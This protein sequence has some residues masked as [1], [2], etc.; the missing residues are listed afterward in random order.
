MRKYLDNWFFERRFGKKS[1]IEIDKN[2]GRNEDNF[3][4]EKLR[5][6]NDLRDIFFKYSRAIWTPVEKPLRKPD[7]VSESG[8]E[9]W[10]SDE[11][12][13]RYSGHWGKVASCR[14]E[15][16]GHG[17]DDAVKTYYQYTAAFCPWHKFESELI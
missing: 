11:G 4:D 2:E 12:V 1:D 8:S 10:Y 13:I 17:M 16:E 15:L 9:Y 7:Y 6:V 3:F 5:C 14:W